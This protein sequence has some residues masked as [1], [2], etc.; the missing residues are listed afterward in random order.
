MDSQIVFGCDNAV[1]AYFDLYAA[2]T[3]CKWM[4]VF[5]CVCVCVYV[6]VCVWVGVGVGVRQREAYE[7]N[8]VLAACVAT[9]TK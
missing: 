1:H 8:V 9:W 7:R 2:Y 4:C 6:C 5:V 3:V